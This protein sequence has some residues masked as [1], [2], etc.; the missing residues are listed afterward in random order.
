M[1]VG[2]SVA[3]L[4]PIVHEKILMVDGMHCSSCAI[5]IEAAL[6]KHPNVSNASVNF[7]ADV[8][9]I[10]WHDAQPK[11]TELQT[12]I[13]RLGYQLHQ[14]MDDK[15]R[16]QHAAHT[17]KNLQLRLAV[18]VVFGMW[19]MMPALLIYLFHFGIVEQDALF[20]L[21]IASGLFSIPV[22]IYSGSH[23]YRVGWRTFI[24]GAPGLDSLIS[25]AVFSA[26]IISVYK[27]WLKSPNVYFD[28]AVMLI[29]F[30]LIAR[31]LDT[32]VRRRATEVIHHLLQDFP[33]H[34][35]IVGSQG[36]KESCLINDVKIGQGI[37]LE[38]GQTL[39]FD[40]LV[41]RGVGLVD[42]S[43]LNGEHAPRTATVSDTLFAGYK[44][45]EGD[46]ELVVINAVGQRRIDELSRSM[47]ALLGLKT[48]LQQLTDRIAR[49]LLPI[50]I[51]IAICAMGLAY[52]EGLSSTEMAVRALA[53]LIVTCPCA[54]S[55][56]IPLVIAMGHA[57]MIENGIILREP[58]ALEAAAD[59]KVIVFDKTGTL[60]THQPSIKTILPQPGFTQDQLLQLALNSLVESSHPIAKGLIN[61]TKETHKADEQGTR[62]SFVGQGSQWLNDNDTTLVGKA[63][64]LRQKGINIPT[65]DNMGMN[66]HVAF[67]GEYAGQIIF[68]ETL[69]AAAK[70]VINE[71]RQQGYSLY[72]LSGDTQQ[73]CFEIANL[74]GFN[75]SHV[76]CEQSPE[77]KHLFIK[78]LQKKAKTAFVGDG[79]NDGLALA[80]ATLGIAVGEANTA[81]SSAGAIYLTDSINKLGLTLN[82]AKRAR[83]LM[84]QNLVWAVG[85]NAMVIPIAAIGWVQP[86]IA[87]IAMSLSSLCVLFNSLRMRMSIKT[88]SQS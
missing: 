22:V 43:M 77:D 15:Q 31:L 72:M 40:A 80:T 37:F 6:K 81:T 1:P 45:V 78:N 8:A 48:S 50:V 19:S 42:F 66:I 63:D 79:L 69:Q 17:R 18:A 52:L 25:L 23:F 65:N 57:R 24:A 59:I 49:I 86:V 55:L 4:K 83:L 9:V 76:L 36:N 71:L 84:R 41:I 54:L 56:A 13:A 10:Y 12:A 44:L 62:E 85:Y 46:L 88:P 51:T 64:W 39:S 73:A 34:V 68:Q 20:P 82:M 14:N 29:T 70:S 35:F 60:T 7:A 11:L 28:T 32:G 26:C 75:P 74:L 33:A 53:V 30:Q 87:A 67:N 21:A 16:Q 61:A 27:L 3:G 58:S 2:D 38:A 47:S 5:A